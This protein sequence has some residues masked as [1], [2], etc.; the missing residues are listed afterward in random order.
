[1]SIRYQTKQVAQSQ[2]PLKSGKILISCQ[3]SIIETV[4]NR[5]MT[6]NSCQHTYAFSKKALDQRPNK[7]TEPCKQCFRVNYYNPY[8]DIASL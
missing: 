7:P 6:F 8:P 4:I 1:M 2:C 5:V 3:T